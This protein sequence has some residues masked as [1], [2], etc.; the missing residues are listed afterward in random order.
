[1]QQKLLMLIS[2]VDCMYNFSI[3]LLI[4]YTGP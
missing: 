3:T 4:K 1:M 2:S